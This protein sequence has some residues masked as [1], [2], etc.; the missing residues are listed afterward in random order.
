M[1]KERRIYDAEFKRNAVALTHGTDKPIAEVA[2]SLGLDERILGRWKREHAHHGPVAFPGNGVEAL[3]D[4]Q[5]RIRE[6]EARLREAEID[7]DI[8]KKAVAIFSKAP[9]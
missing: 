6:L 9:K 8:L 1:T 3:T 2:R 5:R 4:D 7:R